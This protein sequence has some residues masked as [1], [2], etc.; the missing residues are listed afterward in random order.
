MRTLGTS[1]SSRTSPSATSVARPVASS[2]STARGITVCSLAST[3]MRRGAAL[4]GDTSAPSRPSQLSSKVQWPASSRAPPT[5]R[6][7]TPLMVNGTLVSR[8]A[9]CV[10][11]TNASMLSAFAPGAEARRSSTTRDGTLASAWRTPTAALSS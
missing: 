7:R 5:R 6:T 2:P 10:R 4:M 1:A 11:A 3:T 8:S 9:S